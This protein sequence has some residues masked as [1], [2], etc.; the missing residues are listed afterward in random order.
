MWRLKN[1]IF[2]STELISDY[3][4]LAID[5]NKV[6]CLMYNETLLE[7]HISHNT[8]T[9]EGAKHLAEFIKVNATLQKLDI[10]CCIVFLMMEQ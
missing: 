4:V 10:S 3:S 8:I 6:D 5:V 1:C 2:P 7:L 9:L